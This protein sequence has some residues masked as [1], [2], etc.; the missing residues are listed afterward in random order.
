MSSREAIGAAMEEE[1]GG[2]VFF[3]NTS[4][5][6][7]EE[8][9]IEL[10]SVGIDI[11]SSTSHLLFSKIVLERF[12]SRYLVVERSIIHQSGIRLTPY[13]EGED[14]DADALG[15]FIAEEYVAAGLDAD[16]I[17]A[18]ALILTGVAVRRRNARKIADLF[19]A[20][21]GKFVAVTAGDALEA[22]MAAHGSGAV[23]Q[24]ID[25]GATVT[26]IDIGGGTTKIAVC[27]AGEVV[28][29]TAVEAGARLLVFNEE[30]VIERIEPFGR[31]YL[32]ELGVELEIGDTADA[33]L[34]Q[35]IA[36]KIADRIVK[37]AGGADLGDWLRL[38]SLTTPTNDRGKIMFSGGVSEFIYGRLHNRFDDLGPEIAAAVRQRVEDRGWHTVPAHQGIRAT[39]VGASQHTVQVSGSTIFLDPAEILPLRNVA[40][41]APKVDLSGDVIDAATIEQSII[42]ALRRLDLA[43]GEKPVAVALPWRGSA[44]YARLSALCK[45][46][47]SGL[48]PVLERGHPLVVVVDGD[49]GGL[50]GIH[51]REEERLTNAI[52]S[53]DGVELKEFD[54]IDVGDILRDTGAVPV[55][56]K[57]L[58]FPTN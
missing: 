10:T 29:L 1:A 4:R 25:Q 2:R 57:S 40:V 58:L 35:A 34:R 46:M 15:A 7:I 3:S 17:D 33:S 50:F 37:A 49:V 43:D 56:I 48:A 51:C 38:P 24:S 31:Q 55:V 22:L 13:L 45:G 41:I 21:A 42:D 39:V 19:S 8:D 44:T 28:A 30:G 32:R 11:G 36:E 12:D 53:I 9:E 52:I 18:G 14:I 26:N 5:S 16:D 23:A 47:L 54:F 20:E 6:L 27:R